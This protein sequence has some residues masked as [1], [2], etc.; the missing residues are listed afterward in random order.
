LGAFGSSPSICHLDGPILQ[1][2][3]SNGSN[4]SCAITSASGA[5][6]AAAAAEGPVG[7]LVNPLLNLGLHLQVNDEKLQLINCCVYRE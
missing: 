1:G 7:R 5:A 4:S 6:A 2:S 3:S